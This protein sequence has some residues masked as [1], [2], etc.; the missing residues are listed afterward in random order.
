MQA[1]GATLVGRRA[2]C[3][4]RD[5]EIAAIRATLAQCADESVARAVLVTAPA[6]GGNRSCG[7]PCSDSSAR[8][9][10][11][12]AAVSG[13][14]TVR[15]ARADP[16]TSGMPYGLLR[17][18]PA[19]VE[20]PESA[21]IEV[22]VTETAR[23]RAF[24]HWVAAECAKGP[25]LLV[26]EDLQWGDQPSVKALDAVLRDRK[27]AP[28]RGAR[29]CAPRRARRFFRISGSIASSKRSASAR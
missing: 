12:S 3:V 21:P 9:S 23:L 1:T 19:P 11:P 29:L 27:D 15:M 26:V 16:F 24:E 13:A 28:A 25:L 8:A 10:E 22:L 5:R 2:R 4:G 18:S 14:F 17:N 20:A 6:G 7:A